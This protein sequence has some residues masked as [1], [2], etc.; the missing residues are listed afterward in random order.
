MGFRN[1]TATTTTG[2]ATATPVLTTCSNGECAGDC[3]NGG[4]RNCNGSREYQRCE[5]HKWE[6]KDCG[7]TTEDLPQRD[8]C[9]PKC[10][11]ECGGDGCDGATL[12][13]VGPTANG[14]G[15]TKDHRSQCTAGV[16]YCVSGR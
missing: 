2:G 4:W 7:N 5:N 13:S 12:T 8:A 6:T 9:V 1:G 10:S 16:G 11:H 15:S 14:C 3:N